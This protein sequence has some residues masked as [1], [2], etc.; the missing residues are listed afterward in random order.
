[1]PGQYSLSVRDADSVKHYRI[2]KVDT[3]QSHQ[4]YDVIPMYNVCSVYSKT[5][6]TSFLWHRCVLILARSCVFERSVL[7]FDVVVF[8]SLS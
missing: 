6:L 2:R 3:G 8:P 4:W 7:T 1:M 5:T